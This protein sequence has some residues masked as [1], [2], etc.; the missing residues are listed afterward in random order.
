[1]EDSTMKT[2][3]VTERTGKDGVLQ[4]R[5]PLGKPEA[6]FDVVVVVQPKESVDSATADEPSAWPAGYFDL[7]G[8]ITDETFARPPQG[9]LPPAAAIELRT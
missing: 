5:I 6:D 2:L 4:V 3:R 9:E 8:S 1:M 7:A